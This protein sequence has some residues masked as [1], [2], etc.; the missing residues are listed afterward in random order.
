MTTQKYQELEDEILDKSI[1]D[2]FIEMY[3]KA[4][5]LN[6]QYGMY[7]QIGIYYN[8]DIE[9]KRIY[10]WLTICKPFELY[11]CSSNYGYKFESRNRDI[12]IRMVKATESS[13]GQR[14]S[15]VMYSDK[16]KSE[17]VE[18]V[19][20]P[21]IYNFGIKEKSIDELDQTWKFEYKHTY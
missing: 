8:I 10:K 20:R 19:I 4:E 5:T 11:V 1:R 13:R 21:S 18:S 7:L 2:M 16:T 9:A 6:K 14:N 17:M 3:S 15:V 12:S